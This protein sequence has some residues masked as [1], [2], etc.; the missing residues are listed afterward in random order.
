MDR[1]PG[2]QAFSNEQLVRRIQAGEDKKENMARLYEQSAAFIRSIAWRYRGGGVPLEDLEQEGFLALYDAVEGYEPGKG[3]QFLTYAEYHIRARLGRYLHQNGGGLR[4]P[5]Q[6]GVQVRQYERF[7][8]AFYMEYGREPD[9]REAARVLGITLG[10]AEEVKRAAAVARVSSL[11][12]PVA[13]VDGGEDGTLG[14]LLPSCGDMAEETEERLTGEQLKRELW[15]CVDSL[16]EEQAGVIRRRYREGETLWEAGETIGRS[17]ERV[18]QIE[19]KALR[20]LR[21]PARADRLRP[22]LPEA[23][24]IYN[25][26]LRGGGVGRFR[27]TWTSSTEREALRLAESAEGF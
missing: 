16:P 14:E 8:S 3:A 23:E 21:K 2:G 20:E 11:D 5:D 4:L 7:C 15:A 12:A 19:Q 6:V 1:Q 18:R 26:A 13:S 25:A 24:R 27:C 22:F 9:T 10:Q 17:V